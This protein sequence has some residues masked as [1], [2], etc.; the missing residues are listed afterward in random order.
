MEIESMIMAGVVGLGIRLVSGNMGIIVPS[1]ATRVDRVTL[2][3]DSNAFYQSV[4]AI[5][6][7]AYAYM[8]MGVSE[9]EDSICL[10]T[11]DKHHVQLAS[12]V[13]HTLTLEE[14]DMEFLVTN[15]DRREPMLYDITVEHP[16]ETWKSYLQA[17]TID[18]V[19]HYFHE[20]QTIRWETNNLQSKIALY[21]S[22]SVACTK[23][24]SVCLLPAVLNILRGVLQTTG[25][26]KT[27]VSI[28]EDL[29]IRLFTSLDDNGSFIRVYAGTKDEN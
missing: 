3:I 23:N 1:A 15:E 7:L 28:G 22:V 19:I 12:A 17:S 14:Q 6:R 16:G 20:T 26:H 11:F 29:P 21:M 8:S 5:N 25:K 10:Y 18:M 4:V 9:E 2:R 24:V 27:Q 13:V